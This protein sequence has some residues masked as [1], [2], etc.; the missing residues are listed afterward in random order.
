MSTVKGMSL[1]EG[2]VASCCGA[3]AR[4]DVPER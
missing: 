4:Q 3:A 1:Q 2:S